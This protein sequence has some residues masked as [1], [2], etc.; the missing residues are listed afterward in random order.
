MIGNQTMDD[1]VRPRHLYSHGRTCTCSSFHRR[2]LILVAFHICYLVDCASIH[3]MSTLVTRFQCILDIFIHYGHIDLLYIFS[4]YGDIDPLYIFKFHGYLDHLYIFTMEILIYYILYV[5]MTTH[6]TFCI[7]CL[8]MAIVLLCIRYC[9]MYLQSYAKID[10]CTILMDGYF[11][12]LV[13]HH[14]TYGM[15]FII[16]FDHH[17]TP[18]T[19]HIRGE[20]VIAYFT[21]PGRSH[22]YGLPCPSVDSLYPMDLYYTLMFQDHP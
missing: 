7:S 16:Y 6:V 4:Y 18:P 5:A 12:H 13:L 3:E 22:I 19:S 21:T 1:H 9:S 15:D 10:Y 11:F 14:S 20:S 17:V 2:P 8:F